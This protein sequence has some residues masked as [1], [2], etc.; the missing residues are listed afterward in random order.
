MVSKKKNP[1]FVL[2]MSN[3]DFRDGFLYPTLTFMIDSYIWAS[4]WENLSSG[5]PAKCDSNQPLQLQRLAKKIKIC[6]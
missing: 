2:V 5:F 1:L 4:T 3:G 6:S